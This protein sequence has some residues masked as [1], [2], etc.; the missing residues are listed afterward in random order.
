MRRVLNLLLLLSMLFVC[1]LVLGVGVGVGLL[2]PCT[3]NVHIAPQ[4]LTF[5]AYGANNLYLACI[6]CEPVWLC[7][8]RDSEALPHYHLP[9]NYMSIFCCPCFVRSRSCWRIVRGTAVFRQFIVAHTR[10][11]YTACA[12][13]RTVRSP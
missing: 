1:Y 5:I 6:L 12:L 10:P 8:A 7:V 2:Y 13:L 11:P 4:S 3:L 9:F